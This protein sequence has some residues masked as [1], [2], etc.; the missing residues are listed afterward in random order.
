MRDGV[1]VTTLVRKFQKRL[2]DNLSFIQT[3]LKRGSARSFDDRNLL[4]VNDEGKFLEKLDEY[5]DSTSMC[6]KSKTRQCVEMISKHVNRRVQIMKEVSQLPRS[7]SGKLFRF[8]KS[9]EYEHKTDPSTWKMPIQK[10]NEMRTAVEK[11]SLQDIP[12]FKQTSLQIIRA[13][14]P[15]GRFSLSLDQE[16]AIV[17]V[18]DGVEK[19]IL[20]GRQDGS[21]VL[22]IG[23]AGTGKTTCIRE[24]E[25]R[26]QH[27]QSKGT[28]MSVK[29]IFTASTGVAA[30]LNYG[31]TIYKAAS[32]SWVSHK[33]LQDNVRLERDLRMSD[34]HIDSEMKIVDLIIIDEVSMIPHG[35]FVELDQKLRRLMNNEKPFGGKCVLLGGDFFQCKAINVRPIPSMCL[36]ILY[37]ISNINPAKNGAQLF[38]K[39]KR[40]LLT[41]QHR[42]DDVDYSSDLVQLRNLD[43]ERPVKPTFLRSFK[44][45]SVQ[46]IIEDPEFLLASTLVTSKYERCLYNWNIGKQW[47]ILMNTPMLFWFCPLVETFASLQP[48]DLVAVLPQVR[49][50]F[51]LGAPAMYLNYNPNPELRVCNGA[52]ARMHSL[53]YHSGLPPAIQYKIKLVTAEMKSGDYSNVLIEVPNPDAVILE[54]ENPRTGNLL[55]PTRLFSSAYLSILAGT[56]AIH[57]QRHCFQPG[58]AYTF[59]KAQGLT[60]NRVVIVAYERPGPKYKFVKISLNDLYVAF[61]RVCERKHVRLE[62]D[63]GQ[64]LCYDMRIKHLLRLRYGADL[65]DWTKNYDAAGF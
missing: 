50:Y 19:Y 9:K 63:M 62:Y 8:L 5:R 29:S 45:L 23:P 17:E 4:T 16:E 42:I 56:K 1:G 48:N 6:L 10:L 21:L 65:R 54:I 38:L 2:A 39:F 61:S 58:F 32:I 57:I 14:N 37:G 64:G 43:S 26:L 60:I 33:K 3:P 34:F 20:N 36:D 7:R 35:V 11:N 24:I 51:I 47:A 55:F 44:R 30:A 46:D 49:Q 53:V 27:L 12:F 41:T 31:R 15:A 59:Y 40:K 52:R 28:R 25:Y 22:L 18:V 13:T